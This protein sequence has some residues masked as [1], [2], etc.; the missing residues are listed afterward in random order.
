MPEIKTYH[1]KYND[2]NN[3]VGTVEFDFN[4]NESKGTQ[5]LFS[6]TRA[7]F[8]ILLRIQISLLLMNLN[9][10]CIH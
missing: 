5:H 2:K 1:N 10:I 7:L 3:V 9:V 8:L 6:L 4:K